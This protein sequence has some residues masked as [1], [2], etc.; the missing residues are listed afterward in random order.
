MSTNLRSHSSHWG[1]FTAEVDDGRIVGVRPFQKDPDPSP[2]IESIPDAVYDESRVA[3]PMIRQ[4]WLD[5]GPGGK[6]KQRGA[7]PFI[8]VPWD[9]ALDMVAAEI[10]RV[11]NTYG[12][13]AIFGGSYGWSSAGRFHHAKTQ[14]Q[15]FM[16]AFLPLEQ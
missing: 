1:A 9:E 8:A 16:K 12:N 10:D 15:R 7:E 6:R 5:H 13:S 3:R 11:R 4:S 14:M 2:L